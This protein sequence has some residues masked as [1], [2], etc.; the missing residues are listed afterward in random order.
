MVKEERRNDARLSISVISCRM[1]QPKVRLNFS[2]K[3]YVRFIASLFIS[4]HYSLHM[5]SV[6]MGSL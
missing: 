6:G 1:N 4:A 2:P 3:M 5:F